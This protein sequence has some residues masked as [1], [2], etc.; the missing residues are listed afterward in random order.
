MLAAILLA[1][2]AF[3]EVFVALKTLSNV[4]TMRTTS[5]QALGVVQSKTMSDEEK[6]AAMQRS[7]L[8]MFASI[9]LMVLKVAASIAAAAAVLFAFSLFAWPFEELVDYSVKPL[10]L[11][12]TIVG[13][14]AYGMVRHGGRKR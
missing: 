12:A 14:T 7:S 5:R 10:P 9:G 11:I 6:A 1:G 13:V 8:S 2:F 4:E 3:Y